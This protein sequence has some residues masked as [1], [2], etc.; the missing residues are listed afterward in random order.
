MLLLGTYLSGVMVSIWVRGC[1]KGW[2][3]ERFALTSTLLSR[4]E[5]WGESL[6]VIVW[7]GCVFSWMFM[8]GIVMALLTFETVNPNSGKA[9]RRFH[10]VW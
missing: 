7:F 3:I 4:E 10:F 9:I 8:L 5:A 2:F 6:N 1:M